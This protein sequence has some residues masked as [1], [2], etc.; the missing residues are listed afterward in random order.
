MCAMI[1]ENVEKI[2]TGEY[3][4]VV[5]IRQP[6]QRRSSLGEWTSVYKYHPNTVR[7]ASRRLVHRY[8]ETRHMGF[9]VYPP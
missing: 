7:A 3:R 1:D 8:D 5:G 9:M 2:R 4:M 6:L